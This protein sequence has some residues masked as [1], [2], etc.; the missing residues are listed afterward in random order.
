MSDERTTTTTTTTGAPERGP[1]C[2]R[3]QGRLERLLDGGLDP[4][5]TARDRGHLE[6]CA[7]CRAE[8]ERWAGFLGLVAEA[9]APARTGPLADE[10]ARV[11]R[12]LEARLAVRI[13]A[14]ERERRRLQRTTLVAA[15]A[16]LLVLVGLQSLGVWS[17]VPSL[18]SGEFLTR[19][20]LALPAWSELF[21]SGGPR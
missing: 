16:A 21:G 4:V 11:A 9:V 17:D 13:E 2:A 7:G 19:V 3:V 18:P 10:L 14:E 5:E 20:D 6:A 12:E 15:A 1:A 8:E